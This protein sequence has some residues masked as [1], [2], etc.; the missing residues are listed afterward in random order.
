MGLRALFQQANISPDTIDSYTVGFLISPRINAMGRLSHGMDALRLLCTQNKGRAA[1]LAETLADTNVERQDITQSQ[2]EEAM[3][4]VH[5]QS[6]ESILIAHSSEFHEGVIGL[7]AGKLV[8]KYSKP[9][10]VMS[11]SE[12]GIKGSA[13]SLKGINI[14]E[15][16][17]EVREH[18]LEVGGHPMAGGFSLTQE[19]LEIF[20]TA[21]FTLARTKIDKQ[22]L[23]PTK[24]LE[25]QIPF[26]LITNELCIL[27]E[28]FAP[29]GSENSKP[30][31][32]FGKV[33]IAAK[34]A[35]GKEGK[36]LK[37]LLEPL[38]ASLPP[39]EALYWRNGHRL[40]E[41]VVGQAVEC[42]GLVE[43]STWKGKSKIQI[44]LKDII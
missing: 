4:Q 2:L 13:R 28:K 23:I 38:D 24:I 21:I 11:I 26:S 9:A 5:I 27:M 41:F 8:E 30:L 42:A 35:L 1:Q 22:M 18:L 17:R 10:L 31:F 14:T 39:V 29:F 40:E 44:V 3:M 33:R 16:L 43:C 7:I 32:S 15:L 37:L 20:K 19:K 36:H 6:E 34:H 12:K 25:C